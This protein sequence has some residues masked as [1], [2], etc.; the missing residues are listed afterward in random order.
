[1]NDTPKLIPCGA[2]ARRLGVKP[3]WLKAEAER[4]DLPGVQA[5]DTWLFHYPTI[6]AL[7]EKRAK[8]APKEAGRG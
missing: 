6:L 2:A 4:G 3:G 1:M 8:L 5:G 7:L